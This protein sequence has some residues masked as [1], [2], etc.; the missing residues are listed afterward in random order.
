MLNYKCIC[1]TLSMKK[2]KA[3]YVIMRPRFGNCSYDM[4][5]YS[6]CTL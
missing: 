2:W 5:K 3:I 6:D 1:E 4:I